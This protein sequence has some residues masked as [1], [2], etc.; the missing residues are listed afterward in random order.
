MVSRLH[1]G[2]PFQLIKCEC[3][4]VLLCVPLHPWIWGRT[5]PIYRKIW[6]FVVISTGACAFNTHLLRNN[7]T[8][9][10]A[11]EHESALHCFL[12]SCRGIFWER[13]HSSTK[14][15]NRLNVLTHHYYRASFSEL[16]IHTYSCVFNQKHKVPVMPPMYASSPFFPA[17][18]LKVALHF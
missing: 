17:G 12:C 5:T 11:F 7:L 2:P 4:Q 1:E 8:H 9:F 6:A 3:Q 14:K 15:A 18:L 10:Q 13:A 16:P